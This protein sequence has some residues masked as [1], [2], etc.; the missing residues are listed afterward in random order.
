VASEARLYGTESVRLRPLSKGKGDKDAIFET[1][2]FGGQHALAKY[3]VFKDCWSFEDKA[4]V[5]PLQAADIWTW[6][7]YSYMVNTSIPGKLQQQNAKQPRKSY[8]A[9][10]DSPVQ[11]RYQLSHTLEELVRRSGSLGHPSIR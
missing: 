2:L 5:V 11:V 8:R 6:E 3:G 4:L 1:L 9:L 10:I 7:N